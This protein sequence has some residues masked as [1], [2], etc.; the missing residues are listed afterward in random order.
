MMTCLHCHSSRRLCSSH[1]RLIPRPPFPATY[2]A[3]PVMRTRPCYLVRRRDLVPLESDCLPFVRLFVIGLAS[4]TQVRVSG[5]SC[6][7][8]LSGQKASYK[9]SSLWITGHLFTRDCL[10]CV[11]AHCLA[12]PLV[13]AGAACLGKRSP[14]RKQKSCEWDWTCL[15]LLRIKGGRPEVTVLVFCC[16]C[17]CCFM[18]MLRKCA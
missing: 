16:C 7:P 17:C 10:V 12:G 8:R 2:S 11:G 1:H 15:F 6:H 9:T 18:T 3:S 13:P 4:S 14:F 5:A